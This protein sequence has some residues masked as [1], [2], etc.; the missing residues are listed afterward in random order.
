[1]HGEL[2]RQVK[3]NNAIS[4]LS[5][6]IG[7]SQDIEKIGKLVV[8]LAK[9]LTE[10]DT[11]FITYLDPKTGIIMYPE[12]ESYQMELFLSVPVVVN[13]MPVMNISV[14]NSNRS[15]TAAD[16]EA[17]QQLSALYAIAVQ[18]KQLESDLLES[19]NYFKL[20][21]NNIPDVY[22]LCKVVT[23]GLKVLKANSRALDFVGLREEN[24][25]GKLL[26]EIL[27]RDMAEAWTRN[28]L[29]VISGKEPKTYEAANKFGTFEINSIP[30]SNNSGDCN[31]LIIIAREIS[32]KRKM[33]EHLQKME[34]LE[35]VG[36]LAGGI[37][38]DFNNI[39]TAIIGNAGL[40]KLKLGKEHDE[41]IVQLLKEIEDAALGAKGLT[42]QLLTFAEGG[43]PVLE[44]VS[45]GQL[46]RDSSPFALRGSNVRCEFYLPNDLWPVEIDRGQMNQV[47]NNLVINAVQAMK[48]GGIVN[49]RAQNTTVTK[50]CSLPL[51][52]G[53][54]VKISVEDHGEG[55][56]PEYLDKLFD[57]YFTTKQTGSGLGLTT[58]YSIIIKHNGFITVESEPG[59]GTTFHF[60]LP[61]SQKET[62]PSTAEKK[63]TEHQGKILVMDDEKMLR[64]VLSEM[65]T[66]LGYEVACAKDGSEAITKYMDAV[67]SDEPFDGVIMDL[68]IP[69]GMGGKEAIRHLAKINPSVKAI[70]SSGYSNDPVM[71]NHRDYGFSA[72][73]TKPFTIEQLADAIQKLLGISELCTAGDQLK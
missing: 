26:E 20:I 12:P 27:P 43:T 2:A 50:D 23:N 41:K 58:S 17:V 45:I 8:E 38:H 47:I 13:G 67:Q 7:T 18:K 24:V 57:P 16:A 19:Q 14:S 53:K 1:M 28:I 55:I 11:G 56:L 44:T 29:N 64:F 9:E 22:V 5:N 30:V 15:Y 73:V 31:H 65:L 70:V 40:A 32:E 39:L 6:N 46:L 71:S 37:A 68:T 33:E 3:L 54:Y 25:T 61:A 51:Q 49:I 42:Q 10:S 72:V 4:T 66:H 52:E 59:L 60:Y 69:G 48:G 21:L 63:C 35:S 36:L 62:Q 34:K